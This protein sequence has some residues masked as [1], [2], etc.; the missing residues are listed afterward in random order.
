[1]RKGYKVSGFVKWEQELF[2]EECNFTDDESR[3]FAYRNQEL[4]FE[5]IAEKMDYSVSKI[6]DLSDSVTNKIIKVLP[7]KDAYFKKY[8]NKYG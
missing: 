6:T 7:L 8:C 3:F 1:M 5:E 4:S 2:N